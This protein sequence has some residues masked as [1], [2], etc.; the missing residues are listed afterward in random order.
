MS[1]I[2]SLKLTYNNKYLISSS[3]DR[4][5]KLFN[6]NSGKLENSYRY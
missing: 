2:R 1:L 5:V 3:V 4:T 6:L